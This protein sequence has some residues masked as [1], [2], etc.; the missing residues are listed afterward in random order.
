MINIIL[1]DFQGEIAALIAA[2]LWAICSTIYAILGAKIPPLLLNLLKGLVAIFFI[3]LTFIITNQINPNCNVETG[4]LLGISGIIGIGIGDT[5]YLKA[6]NYLGARKTLL[7]ETLAPPLSTILAYFLLGES[8]TFLACIGIFI[9]IIG[10]VWVITE[11][12]KEVVI[13]NNKI[14]IEGLKWGLIAAMSQSLGAVI[15]RFALSTT[16]ILPLW[17]TLFRLIGGTIIVVILL[18]NKKE[19]QITI[20]KTIWSV[21]TFLIITFTAFGSTYLGIWLQQ[22]SLKFAPAG[23][24]QTLLATSPLFVIPIAMALGEKVSFRAILGAL[25][26]LIGIGFLFVGK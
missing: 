17:S 23:I 10:V 3:F 4:I 18:L 20:I 25:V 16:D 9:T 13:T 7:L 1:T 2:F 14:G 19:N 21:K 11:R 22:T 24:A 26:A 15:S 8:L 6:L 5:A 12:T